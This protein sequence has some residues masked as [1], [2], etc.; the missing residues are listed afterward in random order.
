MRALGRLYLLLYF[1]SS[2]LLAEPNEQ[3]VQDYGGLSVLSV[4]RLTVGDDVECAGVL[5]SPQVVLTA[6]HCLYDPNN[7][8]VKISDRVVFTAH[9]GGHLGAVHRIATKAII[10]PAFERRS[11]ASL[12]AI[13]V[14]LAMLELDAPLSDRELFTQ[15]HAEAEISDAMN[16]LSFNQPDKHCPVLGADTGLV[17]LNCDLA[18][19]YSGSPVM[20]G[21]GADAKL[22]SIVSASARISGQSVAIGVALPKEIDELRLAEAAGMFVDITPEFFR[23][24]GSN[25]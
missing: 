1:L 11:R 10:H 7:S 20:Q 21:S 2:P 14:D 16:V 12:E 17:V 24:A 22:V 15:Q 8:E 9:S 4:G 25:Y 23:V 13:R 18:S 3:F 6:A 19:G 5:I